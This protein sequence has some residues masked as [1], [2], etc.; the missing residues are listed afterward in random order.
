MKTTSTIERLLTTTFIVLFLMTFNSESIA[1]EKISADLKEFKITIEKT[2]NGLKM[3]SDKGSA[4]IDLSFS[5]SDNKPQA[6]DEY[7]M[8]Q[9]GKVATSKEPKLAD[10]LFTITKTKDGITLT[11]IEGTAWKELSFSLQKNRKK[12]IDQYGMM[13]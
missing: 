8:T 10:Y 4:W 13:E 3:Q 11:G 9:L 2:S 5:F 6:I 12:V 7:G 1:Q